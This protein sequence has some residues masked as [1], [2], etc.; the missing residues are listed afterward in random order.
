M[1]ASIEKEWKKVLLVLGIY[2]AWWVAV[3]LTALSLQGV[4]SVIEPYESPGHFYGQQA[5]TIIKGAIIYYILIFRLSIPLIRTGNRKKILLQFLPFLLLIT[6]YEY[7]WNFKIGNVPP[8]IRDHFSPG[9]FIIVDFGMGLLMAV[10]SYFIATW[11]ESNDALKREGELEK[12]KL[13]AEL[14][15]IKYQINPHFLFNSL[16]FIYT[17]TVKGNPEAAHAVHLLS[18]IMSYALEEWGELGKVPLALEISQMKKVIEMNQIRFNNKLHINY[19]EY[20]EQ[21]EEVLNNAYVPTLVLITLVENAFK[22]GDLTDEKNRVSIKLEVT[23]SNI[24]FSVC[25][26]KKR[27]L[28]EPSKGIGLSNVQQRLQLMYG[29]KQ[30]FIIQEN[31]THYLTKIHINLTNHD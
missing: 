15:A 10:I 12:Q 4:S 3:T 21:K 28:K 5:H 16:S 20:I 7:I 1:L 22:H 24:Y 13:N 18:E 25:N 8:A 14:S 19:D 2:T 11:I 30:S 9:T 29:D 31:E 6:L 17:K 23:R 26:K 27:G